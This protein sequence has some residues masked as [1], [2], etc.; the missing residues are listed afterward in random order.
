MT[1]LQSLPRIHVFPSYNLCIDSSSFERLQEI[2]CPRKAARKPV[3]R[4]AGGMSYALMKHPQGLLC[5]ASGS[6]LGWLYTTI[7]KTSRDPG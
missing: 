6:Y 7:P 1:I 4:D 5:Q 2:D 3:T